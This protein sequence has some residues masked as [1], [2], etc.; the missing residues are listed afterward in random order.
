MAE[1]SIPKV[2]RD[3]SLTL[4]DGTAGTPN[5]Y[6]VQYSDAVTLTDNKVEAIHVF[7]RGT[8][9]YTRKGNDG[10]PTISFTVVQASFTDA[11][12]G[13][14][15][16]LDAWNK[17]GAFASWVKQLSTVE[18]HNLKLTFTVEGTDLGDSADHTAVATGCRLVSFDFSEGDPNQLTFN[19]EV[20]GA[21]SYTGPS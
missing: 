11:S 3:G 13:G 17:T 5:T 20:L 9:V 14:G 10:I 6:T 16:A 15:T 7:N 2:P 18:H 8:R 4:E 12:T 1:S 21:L 19:V